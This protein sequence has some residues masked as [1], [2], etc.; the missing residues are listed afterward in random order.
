MDA[1]HEAAQRGHLTVVKRLVEC[2]V[3]TVSAVS[4]L[5]NL[6]ISLCCIETFCTLMLQ[7]IAEAL[8]SAVRSNDIA[9]IKHLMSKGAALTVADLVTVGYF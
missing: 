6:L 1:L 3:D 9:M 5:C 8:R 2:G 4:S 7:S